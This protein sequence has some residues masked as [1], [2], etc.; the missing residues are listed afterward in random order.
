MRKLL[1]FILTLAIATATPTSK[2]A[3]NIIVPD[4]T[5]KAYLKDNAGKL[6]PASIVYTTD[7][8]GNVVPVSSTIAD[9]TIGTVNQGTNNDGSDPWHVVD[10]DLIADFDA[11][12]TWADVNLS[13]RASESTLST[14][15]SKVTAV[16]TGA[17]VVSSSALPTGAS[18]SAAQ[19]TGNASLSSIDGKVPSGLTVVSSAL[20]VDG[21]AVTQPVSAASLPL[22]SGASTSANQSTANASLSSIDGK[23]PA[24]LTV[25]GTALKVD[26]SAVTQPVSAASLPLPS[27]AATSAS[28][29]TGN[30]SLSSIDGKL[31]SLGQKAMTASVPV[32]ISSDQSAVIVN[33][34]G[35]TQPVSGTVAAT[36]S[37]NWSQ[38]LQD[39][40]G[41][42]VTSQLSSA[43]RA[44]DVGVN[45]AGVQVDPR[46]LRDGAGTSV[47]VG[48]TTMSASLPVTIASNQSVLPQE[49]DVS[50]TGS[51]T[52]LNSTVSMSGQGLGVIQ[53]NITGTW[54]GT[55]SF[56]GSVDGSTFVALEGFNRGNTYS[57]NTSTTGNTNYTI[58]PAGFSTVRVRMSAYTSGTAVIAMNGSSKIMFTMPFSPSATNVNV[59]AVGNASSGAADSQGPVKIGG[60][61]NTTLPTLTDGNRG[62]AQ[63]DVNGRLIITD[64]GSFSHIS[65]ATTTTVKSGA[66]ILKSV[67]YNTK[68]ANGDTMTMYDNTAGSGTVIGVFTSSGQS[69]VGACASYNLKFATGLTMVTTGTSDYTVVYQ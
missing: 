57:N 17:V 56:E 28:Q 49:G 38:R 67:C 34:S 45:V 8:A 3:D 58:M 2:A 43:Q 44:L 32:V 24:S 1:A 26:G 13:T 53:L 42:I 9:I 66:G 25:V 10:D 7:G 19:T 20:K 65:T 16:N 40:N 52:A 41:N 5:G 61:F 21:S 55:I 36:Q 12:K 30:S 64:V 35:V 51:L 31:N 11:W 15:N 59:R 63:V 4:N 37:G 18:T 6:F 29:T 47:V 22:P 46:Q 39:G 23:I 27:G 68:N 62:D 50:A 33:G 48:Q 14:L 60:K 69:N 54:V